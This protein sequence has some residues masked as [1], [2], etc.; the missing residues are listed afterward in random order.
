ML[1]IV[2]SLRAQG[3]ATTLGWEIFVERQSDVGA[4]D[5]KPQAPPLARWQTSLGGTKWLTDL[6]ARGL[7]TDLGGDAVDGHLF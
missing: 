5:R 2:W 7:A 4:A 6:V 1:A 3:V